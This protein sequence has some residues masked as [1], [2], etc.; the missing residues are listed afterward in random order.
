MEKLIELFKQHK[1]ETWTSYE[2][3]LFRDND[4]WLQAR[5][6]DDWKEIYI[7]RQAEILSKKMGFIKWLVENDKIDRDKLIEKSDF[8]PIVSNKVW[9]FF[10]P[11]EEQELLMLLSIQDNPIEFLISVLK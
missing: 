6:I 1:R 11:T 5:C 10:Q 3:I 9:D 4:A 7:V 2:Y 8:M